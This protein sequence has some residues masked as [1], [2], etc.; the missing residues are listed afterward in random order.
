M[1]K[2]QQLLQTEKSTDDLYPWV[3]AFAITDG[4]STYSTLIYEALL[5]ANERSKFTGRLWDRT[6]CR[7]SANASTRD[8][9]AFPPAGRMV[10]RVS[11]VR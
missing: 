9:A 10:L 6:D 5:D 7:F 4:R 8:W 2:L 1:N 11:K 3:L